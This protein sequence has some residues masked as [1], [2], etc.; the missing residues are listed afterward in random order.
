MVL[1]TTDMLHGAIS[2]KK[3]INLQ[4]LVGESRTECYFC[5]RFQPDKVARQVNTDTPCYMGNL[6]VT[7]VTTY[8]RKKFH[9]ILH[10][11]APA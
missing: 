4:Q 3:A 10:R 9:V 8:L 11:V 6:L 2:G 7:C 5:N 1:V